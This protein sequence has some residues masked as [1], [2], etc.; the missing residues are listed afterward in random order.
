MMRKLNELTLKDLLGNNLDLFWNENKKH[1]KYRFGRACYMW[2]SGFDWDEKSESGLVSS[3]RELNVKGT[4]KLRQLGRLTFGYNGI[5]FKISATKS[6]L[7][8]ESSLHAISDDTT[9][10]H[11]LGVTEVGWTINNILKD[12]YGTMSNE[13]IC[14]KMQDEWLR[15]HL[16]YWVEAKITKEE[17]KAGN[18]PRDQHSLT[19]KENLIHYDIGNIKLLST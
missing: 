6:G 14:K 18:L 16:H 19:E 15:E 4:S 8:S 11:I 7:R 9:G 2:L 3:Y 5:G 13:D 17:H 1:L 12:L 10:D